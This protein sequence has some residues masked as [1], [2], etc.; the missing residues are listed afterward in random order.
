MNGIML[1]NNKLF[2]FCCLT[3]TQDAL[4]VPVSHGPPSLTLW[5]VPLT[6]IGAQ[7]SVEFI[8]LQHILH[9]LFAANQEVFIVMPANIES[10]R[11]I[12]REL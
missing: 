11:E 8:F 10:S 3:C 1:V 6:M 7:A 5:S 4:S 12:E 9:F 2:D